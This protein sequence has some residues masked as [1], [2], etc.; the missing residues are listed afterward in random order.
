MKIKDKLNNWADNKNLRHDI[1]GYLSDINDNLYIPISLKNRYQF[2]KGNGGEL[3]SSKPKMS[4]LHSSSA[5]FYNFFIPYQSNRVALE[6][7]LDIKINN[8]FSFT[9]EAQNSFRVHK[10]TAISNLDGE[11]YF[12]KNNIDYFVGIESKFLEPLSHS[13]SIKKSYL[14]D[15][16]LKE[17]FPNSINLLQDQYN[18][19]SYKHFSPEQIIKHWFGLKSNNKHQCSMIYVYYDLIDNMIDKY[20]KNEIDQFMEYIKDEISFKSIPY[21]LLLDKIKV[22]NVDHYNYLNDRYFQ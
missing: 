12:Y 14:I 19:N 16:I 17:K 3:E 9:F 10:S 22:L 8:D 2:I 21:S 13:P 4:A 7:L 20:H 1:D 5:L 11:I 15:K 18:N 6:F